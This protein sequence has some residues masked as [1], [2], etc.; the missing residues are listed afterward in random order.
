[1]LLPALPVGTGVAADSNQQ[2]DDPQEGNGLKEICA[3]IQQKIMIVM[4]VC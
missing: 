4:Q 3:T 2:H 1:V